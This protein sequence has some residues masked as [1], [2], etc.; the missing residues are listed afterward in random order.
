MPVE[1]VQNHIHVGGGLCPHGMAPGAC[2]ICSGMGGGGMK[3]ADFSAK[4]GEMSWNECAA[5]GAMLRAQKLAREKNIQAHENR[6]INLAKFEHQMMNISQKLAELAVVIAK[7]T[8]S[9]IS[10]PVNFIIN[11]LANPILNTLKNIPANFMKTLDNI[12]Q[13]I[14][15]IQ[16]KLNA[17]FGELKNSVEKKISD[18]LNNIKKKFKLLFQVDETT[19]TEN[20]EKK[21]EEDKR[22]Y[23]VKTFIND[24]YGKISGIF[25]PNKK[26]VPNEEKN[27]SK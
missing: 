6:M 20:E 15:D 5:I 7:N 26:D 4:P 23:E 13:K 19:E 11:N 27:G 10:K 17:M 14:V 24:L 22:T 18:V 16:D 21:V 8:P 25:K 3:K 9:F 1:A 2:P 12:K